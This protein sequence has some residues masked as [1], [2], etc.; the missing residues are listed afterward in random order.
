M[1]VYGI[2]SLD[3]AIYDLD[4]RVCD[5]ADD[6]ETVASL[7]SCDSGNTIYLLRLFSWW[8]CF[9]SWILGPINRRTV[10]AVG[11]VETAVNTS[12]PRSTT[13]TA[14]LAIQVI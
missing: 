6:K 13:T 12:P 10:G 11:T 1:N 8:L 2:E 14:S 9:T 3:G 5:V 7:S 4:D